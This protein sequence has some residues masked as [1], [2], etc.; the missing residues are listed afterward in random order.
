MRRVLLVAGALSLVGLPILA[1]EKGTWEFGGFARFTKY[2]GSFSTARRSENSYGGGARIGYF[3]SR[4]LALEADGSFNASDLENY[5]VGQQSAPVRYWPF[6][7]RGVFNA[8]LGNNAQFL[9][10]AGPV[11]NYY[12]NSNNPAV[13]TIHGTD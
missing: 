7:L 9:L 6:H 1:Q 10:G 13:K 4:K 11:L 2:D 5:L 8:P 3:V 12:A